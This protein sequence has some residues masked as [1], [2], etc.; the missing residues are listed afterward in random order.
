MNFFKNKTRTYMNRKKI[1]FFILIALFILFIIFPYISNALM[2]VNS[3]FGY[4]TEETKNAWIGYSGSILGG[5][6]TLIG[7]YLTLKNNDKIREQTFKDNL[8]LTNEQ[9]RLENLPFL[10]FEVKQTDRF[11]EINQYSIFS[12]DQTNDYNEDLLIGIHIQNSGVNIAK[13]VRVQVIFGEVYDKGESILHKGIIKAG[14]SMNSGIAFGYNSNPDLIENIKDLEI[15]LIFFY[16]DIFGNFYKQDFSGT[17]EIFPNDINNESNQP[18]IYF[19]SFKGPELTKINYYYVSEESI[20]NK[21]K[22]KEALDNANKL[23]RLENGFNRKD[24]L[25]SIIS[26]FREVFYRKRMDEI[27]TDIRKKGNYDGGGAE[28]RS[29]FRI[30]S[31]DLVI[32]EMEGSF[33]FGNIELYYSYTLKVELDKKTVYFSN[34]KIMRE[35]NIS[36]LQKIKIKYKFRSK[37]VRLI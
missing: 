1:I 6:F 19:D 28:G 21:K 2:N 11:N 4:V 17:L 36:L 25:N 12:I 20:M 34:F 27:I 23:L 15:K 9:I 30:L 33:S 16:E 26:K 14:D 8:S 5:L 10:S 32:L 7:V 29:D 22:E 35:K 31:N 3:P 24:E 37:K 13:N 18:R